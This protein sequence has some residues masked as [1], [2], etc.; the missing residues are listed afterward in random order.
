V[1]A[2]SAGSYTVTVSNIFGT[3]T[4][5]PAMLS[6]TAPLAIQTVAVSNNAAFV[7]WNAISGS[8][9]TLQY[10]D[11]L[12]SPVWSNLST[13]SASGPVISTTNII[14]PSGQR[15]YRVLMQ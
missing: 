4:S 7:Q 5:V 6:V 11:D 13:F 3:V 8:N 14:E 2:G 12:S 1:T 15:F 10:K 9:Y